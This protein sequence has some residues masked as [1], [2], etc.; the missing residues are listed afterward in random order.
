MEEKIKEKLRVQFN[1]KYMPYLVYGI[2]LLFFF[3]IFYYPFSDDVVFIQKHREL[4]KYNVWSSRVL[5][6]PPIWFITKMPVFVWGGLTIGIM[7]FVLWGINYLFFEHKDTKFYYAV[8]MLTLTIPLSVVTDV[9]WIITTMTY[10]WPLGASVFGCISIKKC[11]AGKNINW[12]EA[13]LFIFMTIYAANKEEL[14]VLLCFVYTYFVIVGLKDRCLSKTVIIQMLA[15]WVNL[16]LHGISPNNAFRYEE[17]SAVQDTLADKLEIGITATAKR[18]LVDYDY[19]FL[20]FLIMLSVFIFI[21]SKGIFRRAVTILPI[22]VWVISALYGLYLSGGLF[23]VNVFRTSKFYYGLSISRG[24]YKYVFNWVVLGAIIILGIIIITTLKQLTR[25]LK[26]EILLYIMLFGALAGR[27]TVGFANHGWGLFPRTYIYL[28][29][30]LII[31]VM[32]IVEQKFDFNRKE[33]SE[34]LVLKTITV[35]FV[36]GLFINIC[37]L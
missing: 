32:S 22:A 13:L 4:L 19:T 5:I 29:Y 7:V 17:M 34:H 36:V 11:F 26:N 37:T 15:V 27:T 2:I 8:M 33:R 35:L 3:L 1:K 30:V 6:N 10:V 14:C 24:K 31:I 18:L 21:L 23:D 28:Y 9:G 20:V 12:Y 16:I 25:D